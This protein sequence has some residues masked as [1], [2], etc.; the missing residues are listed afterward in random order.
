MRH[1]KILEFYKTKANGKVLGVHWRN[2]YKWKKGVL[3]QCK[4]GL[5]TFSLCVLDRYLFGNPKFPATMMMEQKKYDY[6]SI[7]IICIGFFW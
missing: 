1:L 4:A 7:N 3:Q 5:F 6:V 2:H